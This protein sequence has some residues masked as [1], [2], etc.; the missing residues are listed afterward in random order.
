MGALENI[1]FAVDN[2]QQYIIIMDRK[3]QR[4]RDWSCGGELNLKHLLCPW[5]RKTRE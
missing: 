3:H 1:V 4:E 5:S 2:K